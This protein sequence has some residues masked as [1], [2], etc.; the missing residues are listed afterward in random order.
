MNIRFKAGKEEYQLASD[1]Y[2]VILN[3][4]GV[5]EKGKN[6]GTECFTLLGYFPNEFKA[7][8]SLIDSAVID[9]DYTTFKELGEYRRKVLD[10]LSAVVKQYS[11]SE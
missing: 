8:E 2:N 1:K 6:P 4:V 10:D 11:L 7:L 5:T 3:K 9:E